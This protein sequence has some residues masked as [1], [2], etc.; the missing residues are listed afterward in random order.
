VVLF[1]ATFDYTPNVDAAEWL[2]TEVAPRLRARL[3]GVEV[4]L[5]G[6]PVP[7][8][9]R[10]HRPPA[11]TVVGTVPAMETELER[12]DIAVVPI[13]YGS[14][15]RLKILESFAHRV[16][17]VST[18]VG[19]EGLQV[20]HGVHLLLA[21]DPEAFAAAC[22]R[23]LTETDLRTQLVDAAEELYLERYE[24]STARVR[25]EALVREVA[26]DDRAQS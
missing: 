23:L 13:R 26:G 21:D 3:P 12:A 1:Q 16:P 19:A 25:I 10:H 5:V 9:Q 2:V 15:T 17:V 7:G 4:R 24:R 22:E 8:V 20:V 6:T 14:G 18:T 11:I